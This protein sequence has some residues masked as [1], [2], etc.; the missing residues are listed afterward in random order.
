[1]QVLCA[2]G[3]VALVCLA[4]LQAAQ[5]E[6]ASVSGQ[7]QLLK[8]SLVGRRR[9]PPPPPRRGN[10]LGDDAV[11]T[12]WYPTQL[13][14]HY[15]VT[16]DAR[17]SQRYFANP[18]LYEEGGPIFIFIEGEGEAQSGWIAEGGSFMYSLAEELKAKMYVLEHRYFGK[19]RPFPNI[20]TENLLWLTP[21]QAIADLA[22]FIE[23]LIDQ[24]EMK[25]GQKVAV[26]GGSYPGN[27]AAWSR[28]KFPHLINA[29]VAS[30]APVRAKL[31]FPEYMEVVTRSIRSVD[32]DECADNVQRGLERLRK[33]A[34]TTDGLKQIQKW[35]YMCDPLDTSNKLDMDMFFNILS[36]PFA[37]ATQYNRDNSGAKYSIKSQCKYMKD[38]KTDDDAAAALADVF[39]ASQYFIIGCIDW[40]YKANTES[41]RSIEY[42]GADRQ[43]V[44]MTCTSFGY[45]QTPDGDTIFPKGYFGLDYFLQQCT[46]AFGENFAEKLNQKGVT[47]TNVVYGALKPDV[48]HVMF[49]NGEIDPWHALGV[50]EPLNAESPA[51][52]ISTTSHCY[53]M[54]P[55]QYADS[56]ELRQ[57]RERIREFLIDALYESPDSDNPTISP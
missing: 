57:A 52:L 32:G 50:V 11:T 45:Y 26:F 37:T 44:Y 56:D 51:V 15:D 7:R 25:E 17:W 53:D 38:K 8:G 16:N 49:V 4:L 39:V 3:A 36:N 30:S 54:Y 23:Y 9:L 40:T 28:Y 14:D 29:A 27:L 20:T 19:S 18:S 43:W 6:S 34:M 47:R 35:F 46:D 48:E 24:G 33:L 1:M 10:R 22:R 21:D 41:L 5:V 12:H 2:V 42:K 55:N 31:N 13:L